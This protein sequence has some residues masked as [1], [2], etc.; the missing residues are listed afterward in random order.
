MNQLTAMFN[1]WAQFFNYTFSPL[2]VR[3]SLVAVALVAAVVATATVSRLL[4]V[5]V[6]VTAVVQWQW[7]QQRWWHGSG[8]SGSRTQHGGGPQAESWGRALEVHRLPS[9]G[10]YEPA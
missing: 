9:E 4:V 5:A 6:I 7:Q 2:E 8:G 3:R 1:S 10:V